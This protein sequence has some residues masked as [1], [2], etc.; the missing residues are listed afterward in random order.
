M[1]REGRG[2]SSLPSPLAETLRDELAF[3]RA[4]Q[5]IGKYSLAQLDPVRDFITLHML[6][7]AVL[8][9]VLTPDERTRIQHQAHEI[10]AMAN[11]GAPDRSEYWV[12]HAQ[13]SPH[14]L[15][16]GIITS[17]DTHALQVVVDQIRYLFAIGDFVQSETLARR[18]RGRLA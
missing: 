18:R 17:A 8:R 12:R 4:V 9:G 6:V 7:S 11:P 2:A 15:G 16:S 14:V 13:I 3:R 1:L 10:L 5:D